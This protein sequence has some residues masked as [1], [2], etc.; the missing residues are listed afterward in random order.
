MVLVSDSL[1]KRS[2]RGLQPRLDF[3]KTEINLEIPKNEDRPN[4]RKRRPINA[5]SAA[6]VRSVTEPGRYAD[7]NC[8]HLVVDPVGCKKWVLRVRFH[9]KTHD[10]GLGSA[11]LVSLAEVREEALR[12]RKIAR[13]GGDPIAVRRQERHVH[14]VPS[15]SEAAHQVHEAHAPTFRNEKHAEQWVHSLEKYVIPELGARRIDAIQ[16]GDVLGVLSPIWIRNT[17]DG[18]P[19]SP[20]HQGCVRLGK[21]QGV[22]VW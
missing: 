16:S 18:A 14:I 8:L 19:H 9:E 6:M 22:Q 1:K 4:R 13:T 17:R 12:L 11:T 10:M 20:A 15:F 5:L 2:R 21:S 7:G 3:P